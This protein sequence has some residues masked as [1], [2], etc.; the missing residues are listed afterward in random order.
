M[1]LLFSIDEKRKQKSLVLL[2]NTA[3]CLLKHDLFND[4]F[5]GTNCYLSNSRISIRNR[6]VLKDARHLL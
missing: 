3:A 2:F 5:L 6:C 1:F 4:H